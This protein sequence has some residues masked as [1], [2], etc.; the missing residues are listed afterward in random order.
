MGVQINITLRNL[1]IFKLSYCHCV[2]RLGGWGWGG[3]GI[4]VVG[5]SNC[6]KIC[7]QC[8]DETDTLGKVL[9]SLSILISSPDFRL[10]CF[11]LFEDHI[12]GHFCECNHR[13]G[14]SSNS[15][16]ETMKYKKDECFKT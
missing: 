12:W 8:F 14:T 10:V 4:E 3:V 5:G 13:N 15:T 9:S 1:S 6:T 7:R 11:Y 16:E 2:W